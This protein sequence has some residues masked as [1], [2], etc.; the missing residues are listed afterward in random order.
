MSRPLRIEYEDGDMGPNL[1]S[2]LW[3]EWKNGEEKN[4]IRLEA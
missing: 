1:Y 4:I 3:A 2:L